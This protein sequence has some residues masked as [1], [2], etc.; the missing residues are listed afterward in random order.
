MPI[1]RSLTSIPLAAMLGGCALGGIADRDDGGDDGHR[2]TRSEVRTTAHRGADDLLSAGL[3]LAGLR[4][5]APQL[6]G[7][8]TDAPIRL[9]RLA[10]HSN[11]KGLADLTVTGG[12]GPGAT[13]PD[14]P[15]REFQAFVRLPGASQP[16]RVL[17]QL[18]DS[19]DPQNPC[20]VVAPVSG[21][22]GIYGSVPVA[23]P[24]ALPR[25][26]AVAA[27]D[28]GAGTDL[29][30]HVSE[31]GV[32]LDGTRAG[33]DADLGFEPAPVDAP[34][35]SVPHAHSGDNPEADWGR[36]AIEAARFALDVLA[37]EFPD[38]GPFEP[39]DIR[40][41]A[42][43]ISNGG[44]AA[45]RALEQAEPGLFDAAVIAAPNVTPRGAR[46]L[47]DYATQAALY[48]P[49][50]LADPNVL[51]ELPFGNPQLLAVGQQRCATLARAGLIDEASP[52]AARAVLESDGFDDGALEQSA[53]NTTLDV[54]RS[55]GAMYASAYLRT[56]V[57][58]MPCGYRVAVTGDDGEAVP[59][60]PAQRRLWWATSSGVVPG[61][62]VQWIDTL[63]AENEDDP[64]FPALRC[65]RGL[66]TGDGEQAERLRAAVDATRATAEL[67][68]IP[69]LIIHGRQDGLVPA[70]FSARPYVAAARGNGAE[71]LAYWEIEGAQHFDVIVPFPGLSSRYRPLLPYVWEGL[72]RI[73]AVLDGEAELGGDRVIVAVEG[74]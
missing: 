44:G 57:D 50:L 4:S 39:A 2:A 30:D 41:I 33:R 71:R 7:E 28:K 72:E 47:F 55:V 43:A 15:G 49:C 13:F 17:L 11:Y 26:C 64:A 70:A 38:H 24:W 68:D 36:H 31:T 66:W 63:A 45:L 18:P 35:V 69:V 12:F 10:I 37:R 5:P 21:S 34:L 16:F 74:E 54:W 59:S 46:P 58:A 73:Q 32:Q 60:E 25:G 52:D 67:P 9:R 53:V 8:E 62:G 56:P 27:T 42:A 29:F 3:G 19:F 23:G 65:L 20:L 1:F 6:V 22:R 14:V 51:V 61:S 40:V 48:Q